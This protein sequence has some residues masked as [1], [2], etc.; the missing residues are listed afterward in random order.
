MEEIKSQS[1][2]NIDSLVITNSLPAQTRNIDE[3]GNSNYSLTLKNGKV[4]KGQI[5]N[6]SVQTLYFIVNNFG[7]V[8][9]PIDDIELLQ[10]GSTIL[11][12]DGKT[13]NPYKG[14]LAGYYDYRR[15]NISIGFF[16]DKT[17][18]SFLGYNYNIKLN[19]MNELFFGGGTSLF[20]TTVS[21]G[22]VHYFMKSKLSLYSTMTIDKS[23]FLIPI[24]TPVPNAVIIDT[25]IPAFSLSLDY[26]YLEW[27]K[28]KF[29]TMGKIL[30]S[31]S[32]PFILPLPFICLNFLL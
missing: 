17:G 7:L 13:F 4:F 12:D 30:S 25:F 11:I 9:F 26:S 10:K 28:I 15:H 22:L 19:E 14:D 31:K 18:L 21:V 5:L 27:C 20:V 8:E 6:L 16:D 3:S 29:G 1:D 2:S 23:Y 32:G 24:N